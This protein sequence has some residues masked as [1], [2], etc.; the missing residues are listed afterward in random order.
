MRQV[1]IAASA[2]LLATSAAAVLRE[3]D[4]TLYRVEL[5]PP[6]AA[7]VPEGH[8]VY[9]NPSQQRV[10]VEMYAPDL[11]LSLTLGDVSSVVA[12]LKP[13]GVKTMAMETGG[14]TPGA[15][16]PVFLAH[17]GFARRLALAVQWLV[18]SG[19][20]DVPIR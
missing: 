20:A 10:K 15:H 9:L 5:T 16:V 12:D 3:R 6:K 4:R 11:V 17:P 18:E 8:R 19:F 13:H 2:L 7:L 1:A 14:Q